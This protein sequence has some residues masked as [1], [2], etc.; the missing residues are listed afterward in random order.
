M[1]SKIR[2]RT[3]SKRSKQGQTTNDRRDDIYPRTLTPFR[4]LMIQRHLRCR[5]NTNGSKHSR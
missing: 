2:L 1:R 5:Q 4:V 3:G